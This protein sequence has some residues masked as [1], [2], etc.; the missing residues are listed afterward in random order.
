MK[1]LATFVIGERYENAYDRFRESHKKYCDRHGWEHLVLTEPIDKQSDRKSVIAQ[2]VL[3][4]TLDK[5]ETVVWIDSDIWITDQCPEIETVDRTKIGLCDQRPFHNQA[6]YDDVKRI[7]SWNGD[8]YYPKYG[9]QN[10]LS[11]FNAGIMV[12]HPKVHAEY[13]RNI[14]EGLVDFI[15]T[16]PERD[17][18]TG[19]Y[20]H[21]DQPYLGHHFLK[22]NVYE[23]LDWRHN[24]VWPVY[25]CILAE[26]YGSEHELVRPMKRLM[27]VAWSVHFTDH[28]D[29][30]VLDIVKHIMRFKGTDA[31]ISSV[32]EFVD[33]VFRL[34][35]FRT[36]Y[37]PKEVYPYMRFSQTGFVIP[38]NLIAIDDSDDRDRP[39]SS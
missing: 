16:V 22:S 2:K 15:K 7:R 18:D 29:V 36:I 26:P 4:G 9:F 21:Y 20:L 12:F 3:V 19:V 37:V 27:D 34:H 6:L 24:T 10:G 39:V 5:Y 33:P 25:R 38:K 1:A 31:K 14:Y 17:P 13:L 23:I 35:D 28:E 30:F 11:D 32:A 8:E